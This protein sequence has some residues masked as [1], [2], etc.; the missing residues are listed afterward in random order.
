MRLIDVAD[1]KDSVENIRNQDF[2]TASGVSLSQAT[3]AIDEQM[4]RLGMPASDE[5]DFQGTAKVS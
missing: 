3:A 5:G 4:H 2:L 1:V